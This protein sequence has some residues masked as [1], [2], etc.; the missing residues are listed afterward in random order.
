MRAT[1]VATGF[2][3]AYHHVK[4]NA[5]VTKIRYR[6]IHFVKSMF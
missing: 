5:V 3:A 2:R 1:R 4:L 6:K